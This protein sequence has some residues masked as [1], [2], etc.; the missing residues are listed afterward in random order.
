MVILCTCRGLQGW[1]SCDKTESEMSYSAQVKQMWLNLCQEAPHHKGANLRGLK[2]CGGE[3]V[4]RGCR[5][6]QKK[7]AEADR[8][9]RWLGAGG[10]RCPDVLEK[11]KVKFGLDL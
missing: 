6:R 8:L 5:R 4:Q 3:I 7:R 1:K 10:T 11:L 9:S 2:S